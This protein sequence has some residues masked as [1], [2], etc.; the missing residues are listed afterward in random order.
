M[1]A[2][3]LTD[4]GSINLQA[5]QGMLHDAHCHLSFM[6]N[7]E[8][9][10]RDAENAGAVLLAMTV[11]PSQYRDALARFGALP[12]VAVG[13]GAHPWWV[14]AENARVLAEDACSLVADAPLVGE[15]GLDFAASHAHTA[16]F[17]ETVLRAVLSEC[18]RCG[19]KV[20]SIHCV[21]ACDQ[22]LAALR[23]TRVCD[24][25]ACVLH[26]FF[27]QPHQVKELVELGCW[28][29]VGPQMAE[30]RR[31]RHTMGLLPASRVLFETDAPPCRPEEAPVAYSFSC[32]SSQLSA[33]R[34]CFEA[35]E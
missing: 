17:Q 35:L 26:R 25:C 33:V 30:S 5:L 32:M 24:T 8:A 34:A 14:T 2:V 19:G 11:T 20:V 10:A 6:S 12:G 23:E 15:V 28:F 29:S 1:K 3:P 13:A 27:G 7:A 16:T 21:Q 22:L 18:A 9:V 4:A 31:G